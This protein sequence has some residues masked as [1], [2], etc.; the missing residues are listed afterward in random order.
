VG[1]VANGDLLNAAEA[2]G[3]EVPVTTDQS[4]RH[5]Q[6]IVGRPFSIIVLTTTSWPKMQ[7]RLTDIAAAVGAARPGTVTVVTI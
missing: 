2:N 4:I 7:S 6:T 1:P 5:R 3:F